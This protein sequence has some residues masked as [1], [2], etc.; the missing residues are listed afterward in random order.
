[1]NKDIMVII[2]II[3]Q[4]LRFFPTRIFPYKDKIYDF[5]PCA[6]KHVNS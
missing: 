1:M 2:I 3:I 5:A 4:E 6:E